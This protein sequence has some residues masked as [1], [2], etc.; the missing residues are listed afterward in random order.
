[1][2][3]AIVYLKISFRLIYESIYQSQN[4]CQLHELY[5]INQESN[6]V[7][8]KINHFVKSVVTIFCC[9]MYKNYYCY[10][11]MRDK[12]QQHYEKLNRPKPNIFFFSLYPI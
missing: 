6:R 9:E 10:R 2:N 11:R 1:M 12:W 3:K 7:F 4:L 8:F 5:E